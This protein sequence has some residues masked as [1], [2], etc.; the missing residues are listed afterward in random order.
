MAFREPATALPQ[1][2]GRELLACLVFIPPSGPN[3]R[4]A[5]GGGGVLAAT[6]THDSG[7]VTCV[8]VS[9]RASMGITSSKERALLLE[10]CGGMSLRGWS[11][12]WQF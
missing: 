6:L 7:S 4:F 10:P 8:L 2:L 5:G 1:A 12:Q 3:P 9:C 11:G